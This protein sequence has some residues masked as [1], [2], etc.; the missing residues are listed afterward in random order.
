MLE[1]F[2]RF[3]N[4]ERKVEPSKEIVTEPTSLSLS[5]RGGATK[6]IISRDVYFSNVYLRTVIYYIVDDKYKWYIVYWLSHYPFTRPRYRPWGVFLSLPKISPSTLHLASVATNVWKAESQLV[7]TSWAFFDSTGRMSRPTKDFLVSLSSLFSLLLF[8]ELNM[9]SVFR[10]FCW[11]VFR[12][13]TSFFREFGWGF[14]LG[15]L[16]VEWRIVVGVAGFLAGGGAEDEVG[17]RVGYWHK[18]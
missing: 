6:R 15:P 13:A 12:S 2:K 17:G 16:R 1:N 11:A 5:L 3:H 8:N 14:V 4:F 10:S 9:F 18:D 7:E